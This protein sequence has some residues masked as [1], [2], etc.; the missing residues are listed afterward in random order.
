MV[1]M[2]WEIRVVSHKNVAKPVDFVTP[3]PDI[4]YNSP[5]VDCK[6]NTYAFVRIHED[7]NHRDLSVRADTISILLYITEGASFD[8]V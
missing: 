6:R 8:R 5:L 1:G 2:L 7:I 4:C 3:L